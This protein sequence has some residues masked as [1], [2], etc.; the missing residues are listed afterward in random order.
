MDKLEERLKKLKF[1]QPKKEIGE[2][3][4]QKLEKFNKETKKTNDEVQNLINE[5]IDE[6]SLENKYNSNIG[7][8][9]AIP[10]EFTD[11]SIFDDIKRNQS[12]DNCEVEEL[13]SQIHDRIR[14]DL[15]HSK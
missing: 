4:N 6:I 9:K 14:L 8:D 15:K 1:E 5:T 2:K 13:I 10:F 7:L 3:L 12:A 11:L